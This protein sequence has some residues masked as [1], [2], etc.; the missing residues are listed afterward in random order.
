[1][2]GTYIFLGRVSPELPGKDVQDSFPDPAALRE[3]GEREVV[4]VHLPEVWKEM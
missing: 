1:M 2:R 3:G 4:G